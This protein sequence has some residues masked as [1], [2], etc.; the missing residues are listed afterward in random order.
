MRTDRRPKQGRCHV[1]QSPNCERPTPQTT[2][3]N[4]LT[5]AAGQWHALISLRPTPQV[6]CG[7]CGNWCHRLC[8]LA[9]S[10]PRTSAADWLSAAKTDDWVCGPCALDP[11]S[12]AGE[13]Q[14]EI[15]PSS[16]SHRAKSA[17]STGPSYKEMACAAI[18][19]LKDR[20]GTSRQVME[21]FII[22]N[23][24][25]VNFQR[26]YLNSAIK[27]GVASGAIAV[28]HIHKG[29]Y[30]LGKPAPKPKTKKVTNPTGHRGHR[31]TWANA[32]HAAAA[33]QEEAAES[34]AYLPPHGKKGKK[35]KKGKKFT[36]KSALM[37]AKAGLVFPVG[38][39]ARNM[40]SRKVAARVDRDAPVYMAAVLE[41]L[42]ADILELA[43]N[44]ARDSKS[45]QITPKDIRLAI[46]N[47]EE[48]NRLL[49]DDDEGD[50]DKD[51]VIVS[52]TGTNSLIDLPHSRSDCV[53]FPFFSIR[54]DEEACCFNCYCYV[55]DIPAG[56]CLRWQEHCRAT[57]AVPFWQE[58]RRQAKT[59]R[60]ASSSQPRRLQSRI[61][62]RVQPRVQSPL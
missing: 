53:K 33:F 3:F 19:A 7:T 55:C 61:Q 23:Y 28:H 29:S 17:A 35:S 36:S 45:P 1:G 42:A 8:S 57:H 13:E 21:K 27:A 48:L 4:R 18:T 24:P 9:G 62:S 20:T 43:G 22:S 2:D 47:D 50:E 38:R 58:Q 15:S 25:K 44:A 34:A 40:R 37:S 12:A 59:G 6:C 52:T 56:E 60:S 26:R 46:R 51:L 16:K 5:S 39:I 41:C 30:K 11:R 32:I 54:G 49:G 10:A 31:R 14:A